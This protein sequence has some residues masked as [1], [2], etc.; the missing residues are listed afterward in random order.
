MKASNPLKNPSIVVPT[1]A[2]TVSE[3]EIQSFSGISSGYSLRLVLHHRWAV[4]N[5]MKSCHPP[6][7]LTSSILA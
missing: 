6:F 5:G 3:A 1:T 4:S 2:F 7:S